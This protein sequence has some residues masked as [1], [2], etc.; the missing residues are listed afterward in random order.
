MTLYQECPSLKKVSTS[1]TAA[2]HTALT[3]VQRQALHWLW[4]CSIR[5]GLF[6]IIS[7]VLHISVHVTP[8]L[9]NNIS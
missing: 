5:E 2:T 1:T 8:A 3:V 9:F 4:T 7:A 6:L